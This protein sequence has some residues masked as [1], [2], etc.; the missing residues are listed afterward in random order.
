MRNPIRFSCSIAV[1]TLVV[2]ACSGGGGGGNQGPPPN[3]APTVAALSDVSINQDASTSAL[4]LNVTDQQSPAS[5][6]TVTVSAADNI[7]LPTQG[8]VLSGNAGAQSLTLTPAE[9]ATGSTMVTVTATDPQGLSASR[10]F[11]LSVNAVSASFTQFTKET[12]AVAADES[13]SSFVG[14]TLDNDADDSDG[15]FEPLLQ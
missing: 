12:F 6:L 13:S 4:A 9:S 3:T 8:I 7:L 15:T 11:N 1:T 2:A 5:A 10:S 14:F